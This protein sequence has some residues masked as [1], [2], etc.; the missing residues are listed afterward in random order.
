MI[1][2]DLAF[3][4]WSCRGDVQAEQNHFCIQQSFA[5][6]QYTIQA[7]TPKGQ[8]IALAQFREIS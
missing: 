5:L 2:F 7:V 8:P 4:T 3:V 6:P 1:R